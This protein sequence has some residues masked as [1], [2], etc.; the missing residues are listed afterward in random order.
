MSTLCIFFSLRI[1]PKEA[2]KN[3]SILCKPDALP[4]KCSIKLLVFQQYH[5]LEIEGGLY[6]F[7][8]VYVLV[9]IQKKSMFFPGLHWLPRDSLLFRL[10]FDNSRVNCCQGRLTA[11]AR[12]G[13]SVQ[14]EFMW[15]DYWY[16]TLCKRQQTVPVCYDSTKNCSLGKTHKSI[17]SRETSFGRFLWDPSP[18]QE[19]GWAHR[20]HRNMRPILDSV[21]SSEDMSNSS[22]RQ[23]ETSIFLGVRETSQSKTSSPPPPNVERTFLRKKIDF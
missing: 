3:W 13:F 1:H 23:I 7:R 15:E 20:R 21:T 18:N 14:F 11:G 22:Q 8:T 16:L 2:L 6:H 10:L 5:Y 17:F 9:W 4:M 12:A 19:T